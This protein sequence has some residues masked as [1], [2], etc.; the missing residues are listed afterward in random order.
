MN[1]RDTR[2]P[3]PITHPPE[4]DRTIMVKAYDK[5]D[6]EIASFTMSYLA[7]FDMT[8]EQR[9]AHATTECRKPVHHVRWAYEDEHRFN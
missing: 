6:Q 8:Y 4:T 7:W 3:R 1:D 5:K 9:I 2:N